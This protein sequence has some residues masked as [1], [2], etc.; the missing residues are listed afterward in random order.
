MPLEIL[1]LFTQVMDDSIPAIKEW[2]QV[3]VL[4]LQVNFLM[5]AKELAL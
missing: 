3:G 2:E 4:S 5:S 1:C